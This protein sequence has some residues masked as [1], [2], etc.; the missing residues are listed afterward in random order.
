M[1]WFVRFDCS[2]PLVV[3]AVFIGGIT[4]G[5]GQHQVS[6]EVAQEIFQAAG[7][8]NIFPEQIKEGL[9]PWS[10]LKVYARVPTYSISSKGMYDYATGRWTAARFYDY[11]DQKWSD[12]APETNVEISEGV[13]DAVLG[14]SYVQISRQGWGEQKT[15]NGGGNYTF[16][17]T[18]DTPYHLYGS[19]V[20]VVPNEKSF[21]D[22]IDTSLLG[23]ATLAHGDRAPIEASL[24][25]I[26]Q[27]VTSAMLGYVPSSPEK[28]APELRDGYFATKKLMEDVTTSSLSAGDKENINFE[29]GIKL[30]QFNTALAMALGLDVRAVVSPSKPRNRLR[31]ALADE[32]LRSVTPGEQFQRSRSRKHGH[33]RGKAGQG[34]ASLPRKKNRGEYRGWARRASTF[35]RRLPEMFYSA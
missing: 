13:Y 10:P 8:P 23:I 35:R 28:I 7:D 16:P 30:V 12:K 3:T 20:P 22:G 14:R 11:V 5:H 31:A 19:V 33:R 9:R 15:Q 6:G 27:H 21:F 4:D 34:L 29:L 17:G 24:K 1:T 32:T 2:A 18:V 25:V 26:R